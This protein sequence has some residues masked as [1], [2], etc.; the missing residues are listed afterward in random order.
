MYIYTKKE[1]SFWEKSHKRKKKKHKKCCEYKGIIY[2]I[3]A[4]KRKSKVVKKR[5]NVIMKK[6]FCSKG[7]I[8]GMR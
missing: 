3:M 1:N 5:H 8:C 6:D 7:A 2:K 4:L